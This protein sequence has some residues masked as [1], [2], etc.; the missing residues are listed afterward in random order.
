M[1]ILSRSFPTFHLMATCKILQDLSS[2]GMKKAPLVNLGR[3]SS[4]FDPFLLFSV[5]ESLSMTLFHSLNHDRTSF[6]SFSVSKMR[7]ELVDCGLR[8]TI[9]SSRMVYVFELGCLNKKSWH[10][11]TDILFFCTYCLGLIT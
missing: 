1:L 5:V 11:C 3:L 2:S 4:T 8:E 7:C 10:K 9:K 6:G